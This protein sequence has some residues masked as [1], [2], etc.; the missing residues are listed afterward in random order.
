MKKIFAA[1]APY[2]LALGIDFYLLPFLAKDTGSA[3]LMMLCVM[4][5]I[6]FST[7]VLYGTRRGFGLCPSLAAL[8][9]FVPTIFIYYNS[10]AWVYSVAYAVLVLAGTGIGTIFYKKR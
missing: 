6:A 4:P 2:I 7:G 1:C 9:L 5:L 3:M 10:S 8:I